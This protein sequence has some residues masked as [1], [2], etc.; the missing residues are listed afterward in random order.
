MERYSL[1]RDYY[2]QLRQDYYEKGEKSFVFDYLEKNPRS[3]TCF[4]MILGQR[5]EDVKAG[6]I[7]SLDYVE[8]IIEKLSKT[9][10]LYQEGRDY[11]LLLPLLCCGL[12]LTQEESEKL[13]STG[14]KKDI[15]EKLRLLEERL[16]GSDG[17]TRERLSQISDR[18]LERMTRRLSHVSLQVEVRNFFYEIGLPV[19]D[20]SKLKKESAAKTKPER[21]KD[22]SLNML[23]AYCARKNLVLSAAV[24]VQGRESGEDYDEFFRR[25]AKSGHSGILIPVMTDSRTGAGLFIIG[26]KYI[27]DFAYLVSKKENK[28]Y[29]D[30]CCAYGILELNTDAVPHL[31]HGNPGECQ[32]VVSY[33][34]TKYLFRYQ[35]A[36]EA[37]EIMCRT[38]LAELREYNRPLGKTGRPKSLDLYFSGQEERKETE[39]SPG[40]SIG[41]E[42][43]LEVRDGAGP[44]E[45]FGRCRRL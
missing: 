15:Q 7:S 10:K 23:D 18:E 28:V 21:K 4:R 37:Y 30:Y 22:P 19:T 14:R 39:E 44:R 38:N 43:F 8:Y 26:K 29:E 11:K 16:K 34:A 41:D 25:I 9:P 31:S 45:T 27:H 20:V 6:K 12:G 2:E 36:R 42:K 3:E 33:H 5:W 40:G 1:K 32:E 35:E 13:K 17:K 24:S